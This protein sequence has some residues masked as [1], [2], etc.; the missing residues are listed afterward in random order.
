M[1][2]FAAERIMEAGV[3]VRTDATKSARTTMREVQRKG[4][5]DRDRDTPAGR[6]A[7][8][9]PKRRKGSCYPGFLKPR[10]TA[11]KALLAAKQEAC[12]HGVPSRSVEDLVSAMGAGG[13]SK[14]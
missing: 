5:R 8:V 9:I 1:P 4:N 13:M 3:E 2:A 12:V 6:I 10:R 11:E 14:R 7:L